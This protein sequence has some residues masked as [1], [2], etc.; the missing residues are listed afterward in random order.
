MKR[1]L[2]M[3]IGPLSQMEQDALAQAEQFD[4]RVIPLVLEWV[5][6]VAAHRQHLRD[7]ILRFEV[8]G[9]STF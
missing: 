2:V 4:R 8:A 7:C 9:E 1:E 6:Q 3:P 5:S